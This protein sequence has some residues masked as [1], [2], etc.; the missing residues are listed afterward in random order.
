MTDTPLVSHRRQ[1]M[2]DLSKTKPGPESPPSPTKVACNRCRHFFITHEARFPYGCRAMNF[3]SALSPC[4]AVSRHS[5]MACQ[6]YS[7]KQE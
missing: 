6:L 7:P 1:D 2:N 3:K 4:F 5:R